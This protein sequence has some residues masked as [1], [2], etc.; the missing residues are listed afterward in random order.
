MYLFLVESIA[1]V[2]F[3]GFLKH[4]KKSL[5]IEFWGVKLNAHFLLRIRDHSWQAH[6]DVMGARD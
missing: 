3:Y 2:M 4:T 6:G 5:Y 1:G